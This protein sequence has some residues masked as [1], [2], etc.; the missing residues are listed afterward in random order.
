M[1]LNYVAGA[2]IAVRG[3]SRGTRAP[4]RWHPNAWDAVTYHVVAAKRK[5]CLDSRERRMPI[6]CQRGVCREW[7]EVLP[8]AESWHL[9]HLMLSASCSHH[10]LVFSRT[11]TP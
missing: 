7:V 2:V 4:L 3:W 10:E 9:C 1:R 8:S 6:S 5:D 11:S